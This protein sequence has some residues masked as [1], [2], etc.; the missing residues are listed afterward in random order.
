MYDNKNDQDILDQHVT[1][2][3]DSPLRSPGNMSPGTN[4]FLRRKPHQESLVISSGSKLNF[5]YHTIT[6]TSNYNNVNSQAPNHRCEH[7]DHYLIRIYEKP[8]SGEA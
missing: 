4:Q 3:F 8:T 7:R 5:H 2:V 6:I 1:R